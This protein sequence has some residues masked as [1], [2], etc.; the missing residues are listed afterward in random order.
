NWRDQMNE[1]KRLRN[2][3]NKHLKQV[4]DKNKQKELQIRK[5]FRD[6]A[7][8]Q[9][10][11]FKLL[12]EERLKAARRTSELGSSPFSGAS[13]SCPSS[14]LMSSNPNNCS[15]SVDLQGQFV[16][17][18]Q[19]E[20]QILE[21]LKLE[22]KR[23][24][25]DLEAQY[26][27]SISE[28]HERQND[29]VETTHARENKEFKESRLEG[30]KILSNFQEKQRRDMLKQHQRQ[31]EDLE[32]RIRARK[33]SLEAAMKKNAESTK[34]ESR[35]KTRRL[36]ERHAEALRAFDIE[37][38]NLGIDN[39]AVVGASARISASSGVSG[40]SSS[41]STSFSSSSGQRPSD[42]RHSRAEF[43]PS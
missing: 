42:W 29:K 6:A 36:M 3:H 43:L 13:E 12:R 9:K 34:E 40:G 11:Q 25:V 41:S 28:L 23:K 37:T 8:I 4:E 14:G 27:K 20:R 5:Q 10:K 33:E 31:R 22:E 38:A 7:R 2:Q 17:H 39:A 21:N 1:L 24:Q 35:R 15:D 30:V 16:I 18:L 32:N 26:N 19:D